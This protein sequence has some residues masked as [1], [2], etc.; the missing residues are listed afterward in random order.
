MKPTRR[1]TWRRAFTAALAV[2]TLAVTS[3]CSIQITSAPDPS[4][5]ADT[6]LLGADAGSPTMSQ[7][8][9]PYQVNKRLGAYYIYEPLAVLDGYSGDLNPWLASS[10]E[11][12]DAE[13][14]VFTIRDGVTWSDGEAFTADDV[15]F[16]FQ[17]LKDNPQLDINGAWS[18]IASIDT[19]GDTITVHLASADVPAITVIAIT[20]IVPQHIWQDV[21]DP[22]TYRDETPVG[23]GPYTLGNFTPQQ[24]TLDKY[25][26]YWQAEKVAAEHILVPGKNTNLDLATKGYDWAYS[27][28]SDVQNTWVGAGN[29]NTYWFPPGGTIAL[30]PN[31]TT[32]PFDDQTVRQ[33]LSLAL[34]RDQVADLA[35]EGTMDA[36]G[37]TNVLLPNQ[38]AQLD[39]SLPNG[40]IV[41]QDTAGALALFAQAGYT[42]QDGKL[43][44]AS[45][46]QL[47]FSIMTAN[48][49]ADWLRAVQEV[50]KQWS[51]LGI[52]VKISTPQPAAYQSSLSNGEYDIAMG[53]IGGTANSYRDFN[54][55]LGSEFYQPIGTQTTGNYERYQNPAADALLQQLKE[56]TDPQ[57]QLELGYQLQQIVYN[58]VPVIA[59]YYGGSWGLFSDAKF[60]GWPTA[61]DPYT[62]PLT[63]LSSALLIVT[64]IER[65]PQ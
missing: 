28:I 58:D 23:T 61:D 46:A 32:A 45:G 50:Q 24:Y 5:P 62:L 16:T 29:D 3:A 9:N 36:A 15:A 14:I 38:E 55:L 17:L 41:T 25:P 49:Y 56:T 54:S 44:D 63:Y 52:D 1:R 6:L 51:A 39:P 43:V 34:N 59:M 47:S 65:V 37:Q 8:F 11:Q 40:G 10:Y 12:P 64:S 18:H 21:D 53:G 33:A 26:D 7:D 31:L 20:L 22:T 19:S 4:I 35:T 60:T 42:Q 13:T 48:G 2:A 57:E 27:Y 30:Y